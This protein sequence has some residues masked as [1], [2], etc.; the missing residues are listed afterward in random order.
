MI[1]PCFKIFSK[2][3][4]EIKQ[5]NNDLNEKLLLKN[6]QTENNIIKNEQLNLCIN[7][8]ESESKEYWL[9]SMNIKHPLE[10]Q[11]CSCLYN[12]ILINRKKFEEQKKNI[13]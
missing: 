1:F 4:N 12:N 11:F 3:N 13:F 10:E 9:C 6:K 7:P 2:N 8:I 5:E